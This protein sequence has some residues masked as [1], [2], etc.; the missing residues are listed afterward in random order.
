MSASAGKRLQSTVDVTPRLLRE[1]CPILTRP[2]PKKRK[3]TLAEDLTPT[4]PRNM[5]QGAYPQT[6]ASAAMP[7]G[8]AA[9]LPIEVISAIIGQ[10]IDDNSE[11]ECLSTLR[12]NRAWGYATI[13]LLWRRPPLRPAT[14]ASFLHSLR[15]GASIRQ[16]TVGRRLLR[17]VPQ[18]YSY[19]TFIRELQLSDI[20]DDIDDRTLRSI[21]SCCP[22]LRII[23]MERCRRASSSGVGTLVSTC[24]RLE[25]LDLTGIRAWDDDGLRDMFPTVHRSLKNISLTLSAT[26][27]Q[28]GVLSALASLPSLERIWIQHCEMLTDRWASEM[29][30][31]CPELN[32]ISLLDCRMCT[33]TMVE[34]M[35]THIGSRLTQLTLGV[36]DH[37]S[38]PAIHSLVTQCPNLH[39]LTLALL[40]QI[41]DAS[42]FSIAAHLPRLH[43]LGIF[44]SPHISNVGVHRLST[45]CK[46]LE[47]L[48][49]YD[50]QAL[51]T[52]AFNSV[53]AH[54]E[55][56]DYL[57]IEHCNITEAS[58]EIRQLWKRCKDFYASRELLN[59]LHLTDL[60][61]FAADRF[62]AANPV[63]MS[64]EIV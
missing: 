47:R 6:P 42:L 1:S 39:G 10:L 36:N 32:D 18:T 19:G 54:L 48:C 41:T 12:V 20:I 8:I 50:C 17:S 55:K 57:N 53:H 31:T 35:G 22:N 29:F 3:G 7:T 44:S 58:P 34:L 59:A 15:R 5:L 56:L 14:W 23:N 64:F 46:L 49:L 60:M 9:S 51:T 28:K 2:S 38:D 11:H 13:R 30:V 21:A 40:R 63:Q 26:V 37:I 24:Q 16:E 27:T 61:Y 43:E 45:G 62:G 4:S 52:E 33:S 25:Q